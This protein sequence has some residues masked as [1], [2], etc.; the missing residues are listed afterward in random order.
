ML[1]SSSRII[2]IFLHRTLLSESPM[3]TNKSDNYQNCMQYRKKLNNFLDGLSGSTKELEHKTHQAVIQSM[4]CKAA[5]ERRITWRLQYLQYRSRSM[6]LKKLC[7]ELRSYLHIEALEG[8]KEPLPTMF[9]KEQSEDWK[10]DNQ[11]R[12]LA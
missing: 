12:P 10:G 4:Q 11:E 7:K 5:D 6:Q 8:R 3:D 9:I 2:L 1:H